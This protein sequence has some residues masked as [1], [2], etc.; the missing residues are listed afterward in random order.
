[1]TDRGVSK[2]PT[3][4]EVTDGGS[5]KGS[6]VG[7]CYIAGCRDGVDEAGHPAAVRA[8]LQRRTEGLVWVDLA[9]EDANSF[10]V[11]AEELAI[12]PLA[13]ED[14]A[15]AHQRAKIQRFDGSTFLVLRPA[16]WLPD[17]NEAE[18]GELHVFTASNV[19]VTLSRG[20]TPDLAAIRVDL[21]SDPHR[22]ALGP[23][24]VL[25]GILDC[26]I[27]DYAPVVAGL[28]NAVD[29]IENDVFGGTA[30]VARRIYLL[31]RQVIE[32]DRATEPLPAM[33]EEARG[34]FRDTTEMRHHLDDMSEHTVRI[35]ERV[36]AFR[37]MLRHAL[38]VNSI[39]L[40]EQSND[41]MHRS[42]DAALAQGDQVKRISSWA[43]ILFAPSIVAAIYGMNF[44]HMPEL[45]W[46]IGYPLALLLML[47]V[48]VGLYVAFKRRGWI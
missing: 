16:R 41:A 25:H 12:H 3:R 11:V 45:Q 5:R 44:R 47:G 8:L 9:G 15:H 1:M 2:P 18:I 20:V 37:T 6:G 14:A 43:A 34:L 23:L 30:G 10:A 7:A 21:E 35:A 42:T 36:D 4:T 26:V 46:V 32:V 19:V 22:L 17:K 31:M 39:L 24:A 27:D 48:G 13:I 40:T 33:V 38:E 29:D 28:E